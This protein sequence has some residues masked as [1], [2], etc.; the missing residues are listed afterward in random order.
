MKK[1]LLARALALALVFTAAA[2]AMAGEPAQPGP[3]T[4]IPAV[5]VE[6]YGQAGV[7]ELSA[8]G[9]DIIGAGDNYV[10]LINGQ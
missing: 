6:A 3:K 4:A 1:K 9:L 7:D 5:A 10:A 2:P 8:A